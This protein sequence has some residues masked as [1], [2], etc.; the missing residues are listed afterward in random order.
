[1][2]PTG[3]GLFTYFTIDHSNDNP[4]WVLRLLLHVGMEIVALAFLL[5]ILGVIWALFARLAFPSIQFLSRA[6]RH[7]TGCV[8][9]YHHR[10]AGVLFSR[11]SA[12]E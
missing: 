5:S 2:A 3:W 10:H 8:F 4:D 6:L 7:G 9:G 1:M 11:M 12:H